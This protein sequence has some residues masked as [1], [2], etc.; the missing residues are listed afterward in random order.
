MYLLIGLSL[1]ALMLGL[2]TYLTL[3]AMKLEEQVKDK[4]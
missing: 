4:K 2:I 1:C 3:S